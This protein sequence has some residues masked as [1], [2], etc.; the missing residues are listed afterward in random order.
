M[1]NAVEFD[2]PSTLD[3]I[4]TTVLKMQEGKPVCDEVFETDLGALVISNSKKI[5]L[6]CTM[7]TP[8]FDIIAADI[9]VDINKDEVAYKI[10]EGKTGT[11]N[12]YCG[13]SIMSRVSGVIDLFKTKGAI[14]NRAG[15][16]K[17][18]SL[19]SGQRFYYY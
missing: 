13:L 17:V 8:G 19:D 2:V 14:L 9:S 4:R 12:K 7:I 11:T 15:Y 1:N 18:T 6:C 16:F 5:V 10:W 3:K